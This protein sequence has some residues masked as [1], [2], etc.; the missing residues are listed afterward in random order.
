MAG[1]AAVTA[2]IFPD[3]FTV[4][5]SLPFPFIRRAPDVDLFKR[6]AD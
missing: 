3:R 6:V 5:S 1:T 2:H 4:P